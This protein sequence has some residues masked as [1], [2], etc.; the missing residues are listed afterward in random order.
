M[1]HSTAERRPKK[2]PS[3]PYADFP[4]FP[5]ATGR[6]AKKIRGKLHYFGPWKDWQAAIERYEAEAPY[7]HAGRTPSAAPHDLQVRDLINLF[8]SAKRRKIDAGELGEKSF[9]DYFR[10]GE[11]IVVAFGR[12]R[13]VADI[14]ANDFA[15]LRARFAKRLGPVSLGNEIQRVRTIFKYAYESGLIEQSIRFGPEFVKPS[16]KAIRKHRQSKP[17]KLFEV[18]EIRKMLDEESAQ[19][20]AMILLGVNCGF[21]NNDVAQLPIGAI[22]LKARVIDFPRPKTA[23]PRQVIIWPET[24]AALREVIRNRPKAKHDVPDGMVFVTSHGRQWVRVRE[25]KGNGGCGTPIDSVYLQFSK[26]LTKL[27]LKRAGRGFQALRHTFRTIAD[28][29]GDFPAIDLIMGHVRDD[30]G[31]VYR[32]RISDDRLRKVTAHVRKWLFGKR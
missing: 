8:L 31:S 30:M 11:H 29:T 24:V 23:I 7:L 10:I 1:G 21:A 20:K 9:V 4:L 18:H 15:H 27:G 2:K 28:E 32:Q 6:W 3:K 25:G 19:L 5:H 14:E 12:Y 22:D 26:L 13:L 16:R 17:L